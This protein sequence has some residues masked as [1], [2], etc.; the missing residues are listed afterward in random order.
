M[1]FIL[2]FVLS[3]FLVAATVSLKL[4]LL[5][6]PIPLPLTLKSLILFFGC[7]LRSPYAWVSV[8]FVFVGGGTWA[9]VIS[10]YPLSQAYPMVSICYV[11]ML[12]VDYFLFGQPITLNKIAGVASIVIGVW[13]LAR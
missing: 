7:C 6:T 9:Y 1:I 11:M 13:F 10:K 5:A 4:H 12:F 8:I 2:I 3:V